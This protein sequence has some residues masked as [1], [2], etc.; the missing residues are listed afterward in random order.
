MK[1]AIVYFIVMGLVLAGIFGILNMGENLRAPASVKGNWVVDSQQAT[2]E[3]AG[4]MAIEAEGCGEGLAWEENPTLS[5][6]QSG[7][8]LMIT[9]G[10]TDHTILAGTLQ[11]QAIRAEEIRPRGSTRGFE[12]VAEVDRQ[13]E[14]DKLVAVL[15]LP[16]CGSTLRLAA[17]KQP[18]GIEVKGGS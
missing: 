6:A 10:D 5:I 15:T 4:S 13:A 8:D 1:V 14:P 11:D 16:R 9:L 18:A 17:T 3:N 12:L 2:T 7:P